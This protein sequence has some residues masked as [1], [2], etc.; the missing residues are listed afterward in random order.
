ML[1]ILLNVWNT[2]NKLSAT[3]VDEVKKAFGI[4]GPYVE[5][6]TIVHKPTSGQSDEGYC[7]QIVQL[8]CTK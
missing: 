4:S 7:L 2:E 8:N 6:F 3:W 1:D 5:K